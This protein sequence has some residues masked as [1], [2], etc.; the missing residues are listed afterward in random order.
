[1]GVGGAGTARLLTCRERSEAHV[2][3][4]QPLRPG[5]GGDIDAFLDNEPGR[6]HARLEPRDI[7][8]R[9]A[10]DAIAA[11]RNQALDE[12]ADRVRAHSG[13]DKVGRPRRQFHLQNVGTEK[14]VASAEADITFQGA[15][16][17]ADRLLR[18]VDEHRLGRRMPLKGRTADVAVVTTQV[19]DRQG[20]IQ[21]VDDRANAT[22]SQAT[23]ASS[24]CWRPRSAQPCLRLV[25]F[26]DY[27]LLGAGSH[28]NP[29]GKACMVAV[30]VVRHPLPYSR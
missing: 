29:A 25:H 5:A 11:A 6:D 27:R 30:M 23:C 7:L 19:P 20:L 22:A 1:M 21:Q 12:R 28:S 14:P 26:T 24:M 8:E 3:A 2:K 13:D 4:P 16:Q 18:P 9:V 17:C 10:D 15:L